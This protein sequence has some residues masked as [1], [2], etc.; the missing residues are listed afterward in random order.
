MFPRSLPLILACIACLAG[1]VT[2]KPITTAATNAD[3][4]SLQEQVSSGDKLRVH[5]RD[6]TVV[7]L[8]VISIDS[9]RIIGDRTTVKL[10]DISTVERRQANVVGTTMLIGGAILL[11]SIIEV[12]DTLEDTFGELNRRN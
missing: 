10:S 12:E 1:C 4:V 6:G 11:F 7:K 5:L 9:D 3:S 2:Y 8:D